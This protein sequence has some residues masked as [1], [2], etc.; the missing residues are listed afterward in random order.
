M[1]HNTGHSLSGIQ[2]GIGLKKPTLYY[3]VPSPEPSLRRP[4]FSFKL[5]RN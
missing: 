1:M 5:K 4:I 2:G 3:F